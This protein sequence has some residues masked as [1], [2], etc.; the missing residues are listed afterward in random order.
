MKIVLTIHSFD[1][2]TNFDKLQLRHTGRD[3]RFVIVTEFTG[4][5]ST[6]RNLTSPRNIVLLYFMSDA[7][8]TR[9][10]F[11]ASYRTI[12]GKQVKIFL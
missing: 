10:G 4:S 8:L 3:G 6:A 1:L 11:M 12:P 2:E 5:N 7:S 9:R